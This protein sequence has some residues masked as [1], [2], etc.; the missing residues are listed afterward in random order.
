M[1]TSMSE[2]LERLDEKVLTPALDTMD[3]VID[4]PF[5]V[6]RPN[7][8]ILSNFLGRHALQ[9]QAQGHS[10]RAALWARGC[11]L[12][13][14]RAGEAVENTP[15][16]TFAIRNGERIPLRPDPIAVVPTILAFNADHVYQDVA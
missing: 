5:D 9:A 14:L 4:V 10:W 15:P 16:H 1:L 11:E 13:A 8:I 7:Q 6:V 3:T 2:L 12:V